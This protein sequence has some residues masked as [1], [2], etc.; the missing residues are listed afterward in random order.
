[1]GF[2]AL[3]FKNAYSRR[4]C[5]QEEPTVSTVVFEKIKALIV[6]K[7]PYLEGVFISGCSVGACLHSKIGKHANIVFK[8]N[9][10]HRKFLPK[11][12]DLSKEDTLHD[13]TRNEMNE[14]PEITSE[15]YIGFEKQDDI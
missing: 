9:E 3:A 10:L 2:D 15:K 14:G 6:D 8:R 4:S 1:M 13:K 12:Y 11:D 7:F 5:I